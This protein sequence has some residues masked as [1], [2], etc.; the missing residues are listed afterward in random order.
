MREREGGGRVNAK[1]SEYD[2]RKTVTVMSHRTSA[3]N[4]YLISIFVQERKYRKL[5]QPTL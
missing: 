4:L 2:I 5:T 3:P 1:F